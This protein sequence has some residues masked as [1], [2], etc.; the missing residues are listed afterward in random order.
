M[1]FHNKHNIYCIQV[2]GKKM[3]NAYK[4][5]NA[6]NRYLALTDI[7]QHNITS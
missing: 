3:N 5:K 2:H 1:S 4:V 6:D 7:Q